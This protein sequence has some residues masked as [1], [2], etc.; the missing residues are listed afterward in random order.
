MQWFWFRLR[1]QIQVFLICS[2]STSWRN[3]CTKIQ[4]YNT[5]SLYLTKWSR[6]KPFLLWLTDIFCE[7]VPCLRSKYGVPCTK[8]K[9]KVHEFC[10]V[11]QFLT[12]AKHFC[13]NLSA[14]EFIKSRDRFLYFLTTTVCIC[15]L[16]W[17]GAGLLL[18]TTEPYTT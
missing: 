17:S 14:P 4:K 2:T 16:V 15:Y 11:S 12:H 18:E 1:L 6:L 7:N 3:I 10:T 9:C 5:V 13:K 8:F